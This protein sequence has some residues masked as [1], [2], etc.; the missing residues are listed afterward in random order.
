MRDVRA[1]VKTEEKAP[2]GARLKS[3]NIETPPSAASIDTR[4]PVAF[5]TNPVSVVSVSSHESATFWGR[6]GHF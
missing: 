2:T 6:G 1:A 4:N 3:G 5:T